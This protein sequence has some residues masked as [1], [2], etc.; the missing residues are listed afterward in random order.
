MDIWRRNFASNNVCGP[1][2]G[3]RV[4][5]EA[6]AAF[7]ERLARRLGWDL[8]TATRRLTMEHDESGLENKGQTEACSEAFNVVQKTRRRPAVIRPDLIPSYLQAAPIF[9]LVEIT[10]Y[11][12]VV[13]QGFLD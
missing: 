11:P 6:I 7:I 1:Q 4:S 13:C 9:F 8:D 5:K 10:G 2:A 3:A 12:T